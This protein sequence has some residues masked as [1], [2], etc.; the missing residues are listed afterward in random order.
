MEGAT[1]KE[2]APYM[3]DPSKSLT[4]SQDGVKRKPYGTCIVSTQ[5]REAESKVCSILIVYNYNNIIIV[6]V[7]RILP[8]K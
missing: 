8:H 2:A 6:L 7:T 4:L 1:A 3:F 5:A